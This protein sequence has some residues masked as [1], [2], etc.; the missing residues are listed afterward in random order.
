M[1]ALIVRLWRWVVRVL[2]GEKPSVL[3]QPGIVVEFLDDDPENPESG[4]LY[5][6]GG[7][8]HA[9]KA[10]MVCPCGC[11]GLIELNLAPPGP[12]L[13]RVAGPE[14]APV[15]VHPSV[16]RTTGCRSHFWIRNGEVVWC[17]DSK[18]TR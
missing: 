1:V 2:F 10:V 9:W 15:T 7:R 14:G 4:T 17:D 5:L 3:K 16:W 11:K 6:V 13:W 18:P 12:P 8:Q